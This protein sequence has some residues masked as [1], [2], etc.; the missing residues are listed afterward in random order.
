MVFKRITLTILPQ[1]FRGDHRFSR[2]SLAGALPTDQVY[3]LRRIRAASA[4]A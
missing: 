2:S 1:L 3:D 4:R